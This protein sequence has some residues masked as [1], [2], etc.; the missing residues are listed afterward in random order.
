[1]IAIIAVLTLFGFGATNV[2]LGADPTLAEVGDFE[3][4]QNVLAVETER[5]KMRLLSRMGPDFDPSSIDP[6]QLQ[7]YAL[8]QLINRQVIYQTAGATGHAHVGRQGE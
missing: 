3:I 2:F 8:Q 5:E 7:D 4:T 1:M 6:L